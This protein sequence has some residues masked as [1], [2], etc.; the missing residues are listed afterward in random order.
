M[1]R[2]FLPKMVIFPFFSTLLGVTTRFIK[3]A[4]CELLGPWHG[5]H[6][7]CSSAKLRSCDAAVGM[8]KQRGMPPTSKGSA[9]ETSRNGGLMVVSGGLKP[10]KLGFGWMDLAALAGFQLESHNF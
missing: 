3:V 10:G 4:W 8:S 6:P 7:S 9:G 5:A 1:P 2:S